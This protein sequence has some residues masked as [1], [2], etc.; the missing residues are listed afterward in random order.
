MLKK[1]ARVSEIVACLN[2]PRQLYFNLNSSTRGKN[3]MAYLIHLFLRELSL[4]IP[5]LL[6]H[7]HSLLEE[8]KK[9]LEV[10]A[11]EINLIYRNDLINIDSEQLS[12]AKGAVEVE[13]QKIASGIKKSID[14]YGKAQ[15]YQLLSPWKLELEMNSP[16]YMLVG[17]LDKILRIDNEI[18]PSIIKTGSLP[19]YGVWYSDRI[20]LAAYSILLEENFDVAIKRGIV[21][22]IRSGTVRE[23][24][25]K[26]QDRRK[27]LEIKDK[28]LKIKNG[29]FPEQADSSECNHCSFKTNCESRVSLASKYF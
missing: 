1:F 3:S 19:Q 28:V 27:V 15:L 24:A 20:Q 10:I 18:I 29:N 13:L 2:C 23:I 16:K 17:R 22:Y 21:E 26:P 5:S 6:A 25:I 4:R 7:E 8:L 14:I 12:L 9:A 11:G